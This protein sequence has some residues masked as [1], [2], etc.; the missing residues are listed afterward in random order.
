MKALLDDR[1]P[2]LRGDGREVRDYL[3]VADAVDGLLAAALDAGR[4]GVAGE[5]F[6]LGTGRGTSTLEVIDTL[7]RIGGRPNRRPLLGKRTQPS[8]TCLVDV[9]KIAEV[10]GW[11]APTSLERGLEATWNWSV[12]QRLDS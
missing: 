11:S 6:N 8:G 3:F 2:L 4:R 1:D 9:K 10:I 7:V 12:A 5:A